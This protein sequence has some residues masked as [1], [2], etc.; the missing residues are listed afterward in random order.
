MTEP[1]KCPETNPVACMDYHTPPCGG[2][3]S[4]FTGRD[5][6]QAIGSAAVQHH[7]SPPPPPELIEP[8]IPR[9]PRP[10][11]APV[12]TETVGARQFGTLEQWS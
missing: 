2:S 6:L 5:H 3:S 7:K 12:R 1:K 11:P 9:T 10:L 4:L 8:M